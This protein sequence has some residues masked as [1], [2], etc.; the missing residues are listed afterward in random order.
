MLI[1]AFYKNSKW[2]YTNLKTKLKTCILNN[3]SKK[4]Q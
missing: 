4:V 2:A 1:K 3:Y